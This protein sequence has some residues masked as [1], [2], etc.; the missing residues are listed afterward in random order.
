M[1]GSRL[2]GACAAALVASMLLVVPAG[3]DPA[4]AGAA[5]GYGAKIDITDQNVVTEP[6]AASTLAADDVSATTV[7]VPAS[8]LAVSG[9]SDGQRCGPQRE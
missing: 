4:K 7:D 5:S 2:A 6:Q 1:A 9:T 3:A 8:P